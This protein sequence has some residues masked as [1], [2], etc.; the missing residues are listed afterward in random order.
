MPST[1][2]AALI[3][4][5]LLDDNDWCSH[6]CPSLSHLICVLFQEK[7]LCAKPRRRAFQRYDSYHRLL[8]VADEFGVEEKAS[9]ET[10]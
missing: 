1:A 3:V 10:R 6:V 9:S 8:T 4:N 2:D 7:R 5:T